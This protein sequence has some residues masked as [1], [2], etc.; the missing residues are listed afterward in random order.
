[1]IEYKK[2][3]VPHAGTPSD[4]KALSHAIKIAK[5]ANSSLTLLHVIEPVPH[6]KTIGKS[7]HKKFD[8]IKLIMKDE[9][10]QEMQRRLEL[11]K[12]ENIDTKLKVTT[13]YPAEEI[14]MFVKRDHVDLIV[15]AERREMPRF[16]KILKLGS[17][18]RKVLEYN[19]CPIFIVNV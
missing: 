1:M 3:L 7:L 10:E 8:E 6:P 5:F 18:S 4:D 9:M 19:L 13:G 2:I 12:K 17:V 14:A 16:K 11:C 15:M